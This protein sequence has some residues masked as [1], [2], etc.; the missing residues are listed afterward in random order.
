MYLAIVF[1]VFP[2]SYMVARVC[3]FLLWLLKI[4]C[5]SPQKTCF[6]KLFLSESYE[7][8]FREHSVFVLSLLFILYKLFS[9]F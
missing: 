1:G 6:M 5:F 7:V 3:W 9:I 2:D 8:V 4:Q